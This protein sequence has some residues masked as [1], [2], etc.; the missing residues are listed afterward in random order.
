MRLVAGAWGVV[1]VA[2]GLGIIAGCAGGGD[3]DVAS[4][5]DDSIRDQIDGS[6]AEGRAALD[7]E[8]CLAER[9]IPA[10]LGRT[11]DGVAYVSLFPGGDAHVYLRHAGQASGQYGGDGQ[12]RADEAVAAEL[13]AS[14]ADPA[15]ALNGEDRTAD[16]V[17]C[18]ESSGYDLSTGSLDA[19]MIDKVEAFTMAE[20]ADWAACARQHG[21][22]DLADPEL[23]SGNPVRMASVALPAW[24]TKEQLREALEACPY[25]T[26]A[27]LAYEDELNAR[28]NP[29]MGL[30][31][32][33]FSLWPETSDP[34][35]ADQ[36]LRMIDE[37]FR[38]PARQSYYDRQDAQN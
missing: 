1:A 7:M 30:V 24:V 34:E 12:N 32:A 23:L 25:P 36:L 15:L 20:G 33:E 4:L 37:D 2:M 14:Q 5:D 3:G 18:L 26:D 10:R 28:L 17:A 29:D 31:Q 9:K 6:T 11:G 19:A 35:T 13:D 38:A 8:A 27:T 21:L 16:L 22:P